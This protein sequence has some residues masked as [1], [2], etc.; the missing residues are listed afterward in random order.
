[1][2]KAHDADEELWNPGGVSGWLGETTSSITS[3]EELQ[4]TDQL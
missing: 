3:G 2:L 1:V 4:A